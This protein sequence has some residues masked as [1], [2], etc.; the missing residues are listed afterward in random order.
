M[1]SKCGGGSSQMPPPR[2]AITTASL[3]NGTLDTPYSQTVQASGGVGP[4]TWSV[5]GGTLPHNLALSNSATNTAMISGTPDTAAQGVAFTVAVTDSASQSVAQPYTVSILAEPD[6]LTLS[7][8]NLNFAAQLLG[9]PSGAQAETLANSG[10]SAVVITNVALAGT[11]TADFSQG[12][13]CGSSL[14]AGANCSINVTFMPTQLGPRS[15]SVTIADSTAGSPHSASLNGMGLTSGPN[16]TWSATSL[17]FDDEVIN[18]TSR[19]TSLTLSNYGT[20]ALNI[21]TITASANFAETDN[22]SGTSLASGANCTVN[23]TFTPNATGVFNGTISV[24]D[25]APGSPQ[26]VSLNGTGITS[27]YTLTGF[28]FHQI[29]YI[30]NCTFTQDLAQCPAGQQAGTPSIEGCFFPHNASVD[31]SRPCSVKGTY[32][33]SG[34]CATAFTGAA[35]SRAA[36][37][38]AGLPAPRSDMSPKK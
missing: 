22:C 15:A 18:T 37:S 4:F 5:S 6:T 3:P 23:V 31:L 33:G 27:Q 17:T 9:T 25:N 13:T 2:L 36:A 8:P 21:A 16:A 20:T 35:K 11:D 24:S 7:S 32:G 28:C 29:N 34:Y 1:L 10:T 14:A 38:G 12:N 30:P 19:A 26:T